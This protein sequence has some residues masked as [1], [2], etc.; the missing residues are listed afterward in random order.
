M[1]NQPE[2]I[3]VCQNG[4]VS[5]ENEELNWAHFSY[6]LRSN[7]AHHQEFEKDFNIAWRSDETRRYP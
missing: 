1:I 4:L 2:V 7:S 6:V 5:C 3:A